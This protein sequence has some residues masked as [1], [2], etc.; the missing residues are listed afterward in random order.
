M[1]WSKTSAFAHPFTTVGSVKGDAQLRRNRLSYDAVARLTWL[2]YADLIGKKRKQLQ[3]PES[4]FVKISKTINSDAVPHTYCFSPSLLPKPKDWGDWIDVVGFSF[5]NSS[6]S[7]SDYEPSDDLERFL[8][9]GPAPIYVGFGSIVGFDM[10]HL[11]SIILQAAARGGHRVIVCQGWTDLQLPS[12]HDVMVIKECPHDWL[13]PRCSAVIHHG[14]AGTTSMGLRYGLPT[15]ILSFFGDQSFW[16]QVVYNAGAGPISIPAKDASLS[17]LEE[18]LATLAQDPTRQAAGR[19]RDAI[20]QEDGSEAA[21]QSFL[22]HLPADIQPSDLGSRLR[23]QYIHAPTGLKLSGLEAA[24]LTAHGRVSQADLQEVAVK[25]FDLVD[26]IQGSFNFVGKAAESIYAGF[27]GSIRHP[28]EGYKQG[29]LVRGVGKGLGGLVAEPSKGAIHVLNDLSTCLARTQRLYDPTFKPPGKITGIKS[30][31]KE[32]FKSWGLNSWGAITDMVTKPV[33]LGMKEGALGAA[34]GLAIGIV[35]VPVKLTAGSL[36]LLVLPTRGAVKSIQKQRTKKK[37][38]KSLDELAEV[39]SDAGSSTSNFYADGHRSTV[40]SPSPR[41][42]QADLHRSA[43]HYDD[44]KRGGG[45]GAPYDAKLPAYEQA[46]SGKGG[47]AG[48]ATDGPSGSATPPES[49]V[50]A[51]VVAWDVEAVLHAWDV[52]SSGVVGGGGGGGGDSSGDGSAKDGRGV[53]V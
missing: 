43:P 14:G 32:G 35:N 52:A 39:R 41:E 28:I 4:S 26:E 19:L 30:G 12:S 25:R 49:D 3:Q 23:A 46:M 44:A 48:W 11:Y 9:E 42:S 31:A 34:K 53:T 5:E 13:F 38:A 16:G 37:H 21:V 22:R 2:G 1:P 47:S 8:R 36:D 50:E 29:H 15:L 6:T 24:T 18:A 27:A 45:G 17:F 20:A 51:D 33:E 40:A 10:K 7:N